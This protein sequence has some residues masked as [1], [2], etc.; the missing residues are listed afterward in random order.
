MG[1]CAPGRHLLPL[2]A[3]HVLSSTVGDDVHACRAA[4][5]ACARAHTPCGRSPANLHAM[6]SRSFNDVLLRF[7][8]VLPAQ[9]HKQPIAVGDSM[10]VTR[11]HTPHEAPGQQLVVQ[12]Q[13]PA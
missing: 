13:P 2:I 4:R 10:Q 3:R 6:M 5:A 11:T 12:G 9:V 1:R 7:M 8:V